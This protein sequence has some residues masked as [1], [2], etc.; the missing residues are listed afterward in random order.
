VR[1]TP[2]AFAIV[3]SSSMTASFGPY[4]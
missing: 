1:E 4:R 3:R 2:T